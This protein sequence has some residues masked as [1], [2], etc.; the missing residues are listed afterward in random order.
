VKV[1]FRPLLVNGMLADSDDGPVILIDSDQSI[2]EQ[3][4]TFWHEALH[5]LGLT[6]EAKVEE[7]ARRLYAA[8]PEIINVIRRPQNGEG[9]K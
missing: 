1:I 9:S 4:V 6:D 2:C 5:L 3:G 7:M 8:V